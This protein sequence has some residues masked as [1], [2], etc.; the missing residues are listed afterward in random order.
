[1]DKDSTILL[2]TGNEM[3]VMGLGTWELTQDTAGAVALALALGYR[4]MDTSSDYGTQPGIGE[5]RK[6][7]NIDR[8]SLYIVTKV[9]EMDDAYERTKSNM[10]ELGL[11]YVDLMLLHRPPPTGA[12]EELWE[13]LIRAKKEGLTRDIGV[14]NYPMALIETLIELSGEVPVVNQIEWSPF[15]YSREMTQY[16]KEKNIVIQAYSPLTRRKRLNDR[17]LIQVAGKYHKSTAQ[18]LIR[19]NLQL[20]TVPIPKANQSKHLEENIDV[21]DFELDE[22]DMRLLSSRNEQYSSLGSLPYV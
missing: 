20:G 6:E 17:M 9:E 4:L 15:G 18:I 22:D 1:M 8:K 14:S 3:P 19:W 16:C 13:G 2:H 5:G 10:Q 11:D 7:S 21:F 12:G